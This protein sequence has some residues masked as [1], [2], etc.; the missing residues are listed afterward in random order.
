MDILMILLRIIH[1][2]CGVFWAGTIMM[3]AVFLYP[4]AGASGPEGGKFMQTLVKTR[5]LPV[6]MSTLATL[7]I[8]AGLWMYWLDSDGFSMQWIHT[9]FGHLLTVGGIAALLAYSFGMTIVRPAAGRMGKMAAEIAA[10]GA[11]PTPA[12]MQEIGGLRMKMFRWTKIMAWLLA[13]CVVAM[14][15]ARYM[16]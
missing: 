4:A 8:I 9:G 13:L 10:A 16:I 5:N 11:P 3:M 6:V 7:S 12:Q 1:I 2:L 15:I 14:S